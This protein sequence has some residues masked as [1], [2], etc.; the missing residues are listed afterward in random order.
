VVADR[1]DERQVWQRQL[2]L[3]A[4]SPENGAPQPSRAAS[5]LHGKARLPDPGLAGEHDE[6]PL[7]S[8]R[9]EQRILEGG[10]LILPLHEDWAQRTTAHVVILAAGSVVG[11]DFGGPH[12]PGHASGPLK[13][14]GR[15]ADQP[16]T[17]KHPM[18]ENEFTHE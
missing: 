8:V 13:R 7:A 9:R 3:A 5:K 6:L 10:Q 14:P 18:G 4:A 17:D 2:G 11:T 15:R 12:L 1:L 16:N